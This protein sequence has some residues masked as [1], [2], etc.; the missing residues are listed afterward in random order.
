MNSRTSRQLRR[1]VD[2]PDGLSRDKNV[3]IPKVLELVNPGTIVLLHDVHASTMDGQDQLIT[4]RQDRGCHH[5]T[6]PHLFHGLDMAN[7]SWHFCRGNGYPCTPGQQPAPEE[8]RRQP[9]RHVSEH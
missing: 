8:S 1:A 9:V 3:F 4:E 7:G 5:V 2:S 6:V